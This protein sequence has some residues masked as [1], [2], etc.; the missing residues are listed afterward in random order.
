MLFF[1]YIGYNATVLAYGQTGSGKTYTMGGAHTNIKIDDVTGIIP[2]VLHDLFS[3]FNENSSRVF[4]IKAS[5][6]EVSIVSDI[7]TCCCMWLGWCFSEA[8]DLCHQINDLLFLFS[9]FSTMY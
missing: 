6:L 3:E 9:S 4:T 2:R 1:Y 5:Y 7:K 8:E